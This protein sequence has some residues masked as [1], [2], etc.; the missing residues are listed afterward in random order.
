[1]QPQARPQMQPQSR[2]QAPERSAAPSRGDRANR[3]GN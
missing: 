3:G 1:M 2:P